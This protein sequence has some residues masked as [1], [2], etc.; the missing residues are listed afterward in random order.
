MEQW[1]RATKSRLTPKEPAQR[2]SPTKE[3]SPMQ[4]LR[5]S[6]LEE[7]RKTQKFTRAQV[8]TGS[9]GPNAAHG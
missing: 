6:L 1:D 7:Q 8:P 2:M 3:L 4:S 5:T 9:E